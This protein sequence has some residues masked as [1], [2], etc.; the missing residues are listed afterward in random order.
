[1]KSFIGRGNNDNDPMRGIIKYFTPEG[2]ELSYIDPWEE[3]KNAQR[4]EDIKE[5]IIE[6]S[7]KTIK[8]KILEKEKAIIENSTKHP[9]QGIINKKLKGSK[10]KKK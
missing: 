5:L 10:K 6:S 7:T 8:I 2:K 9:L 3:Q 4:T 1:M